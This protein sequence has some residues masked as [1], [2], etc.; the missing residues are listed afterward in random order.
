VLDRQ[1]GDFADVVPSCLFSETRETQRGLTTTTVLLGQVDG[2]FVN[3]LAGVSGKCSEELRQRSASI[4]PAVN[5]FTHSSVT[6]AGIAVSG[7]FLSRQ[8]TIQLT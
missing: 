5:E 6:V 1:L 3:H 4:N 8:R 7:V 2:E